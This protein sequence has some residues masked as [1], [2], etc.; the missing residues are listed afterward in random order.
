MLNTI[1][2]FIHTAKEMSV[3]AQITIQIDS[4]WKTIL[5][6]FAKLLLQDH[7]RKI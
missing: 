3:C 7:P 4:R 1:P 6:I 5:A 2:I